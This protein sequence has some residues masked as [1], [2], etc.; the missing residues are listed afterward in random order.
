MFVNCI[1]DIRL[2]TSPTLGIMGKCINKLKR[3]VRNY[4][5][6]ATE[7][8]KKNFY[9]IKSNARTD[10]RCIRCRRLT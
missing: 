2:L 7:R 9:N 10:H 8:R 3:H 6:I 4:I 1:Q 5:F